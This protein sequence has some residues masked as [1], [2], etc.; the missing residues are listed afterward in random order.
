M[1]KY[2][3]SASNA[4]S[5]CVAGKG[6]CVVEKCVIDLKLQNIRLSGILC[7]IKC[8]NNFTGT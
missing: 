7:N 1:Y 4:K 2:D 5:M 8:N 6:K 3:K